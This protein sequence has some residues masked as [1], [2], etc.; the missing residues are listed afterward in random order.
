MLRFGSTTGKRSALGIVP[1]RRTARVGCLRQKGQGLH[2][3]SGLVE[4]LQDI[5]SKGRAVSDFATSPLGVS[6]INKLPSSDRGARPGFAGEKHAIQ[7]LPNGKL[8]RANY[9]GP[10][11]QVVKRI[12][13]G[14]PPRTLSDKVAQAHDIR[15]GLAK[16]QRDVSSADA[17]MI[18]KLKDMI[19]K[20]QGNKVNIN[21]GLRPIQAKAFAE[22]TGLA[23]PG[24]IASFGGV[25]SADKPLLKS[26]LNELEQEGYGVLP[27]EELLKKIKKNIRKERKAKGQASASGKSSPASH[28]KLAKLLTMA[29][30]SK[31]IPQIMKALKSEGL[32]G[33]GKMSKAI[34]LKLYTA[35]LQAL[36][37]PARW[38][39]KT[40]TKALNT[41]ASSSRG[42]ARRSHTVGR[43]LYLAGTGLDNKKGIKKISMSMAK[44]IMPLLVK[45]SM[46]G[47]GSEQFA[48]LVKRTSN[49]T[50]L[51][52]LG[53]KLFDILAN[54]LK[55]M[56][57]PKKK[58]QT[59]AGFWRDFARGFAS[60]V[61]PGLSVL[62]TAAP[63]IPLLV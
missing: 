28:S 26:K 45:M 25:S 2:Y 16:S 59:G 55:S 3:G 58:L 56:I 51:D 63:L 40:H 18:K 4:D 61:K 41:G 50:L 10:G 1:H 49:P 36:A 33:S 54:R 30:C 12:K 29:T 20:K 19:A 32:K 46:K 31:V 43:G 22:R 39:S 11:T 27:G 35:T 60:V 57:R 37:K 47:S 14:D 52:K 24:A 9:M 23:K 48:D 17:K 38:G 6:L 34:K 13:R 5:I 53:R 15:Y 62:K 44:S 42:L 21:V 8:G 7:I